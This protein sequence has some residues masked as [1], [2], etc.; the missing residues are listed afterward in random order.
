MLNETRMRIRVRNHRLV[1]L[2]RV[3]QLDA[4]Q[5]AEVIDV[6]AVARHECDDSGPPAA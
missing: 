4:V 3:E 5:I 6:E 2:R 1:E